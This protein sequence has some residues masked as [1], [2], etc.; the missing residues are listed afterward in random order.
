MDVAVA[1]GP[2]GVTLRVVGDRWWHRQGNGYVLG[3]VAP[4]ERVPL[5]WERAFGGRSA[6]PDGERVERRN[7]IGCGFRHPD[8]LDWPDAIP[9]P[10]VEDPAQPHTALGTSG[11]PAGVLPIGAHWWPRPQW[12]GT[13]DD[14]WQ[15]GRAPYLPRDFDR[16]FLHVAP[17]PLVA[18]APLT[19]G[20]PIQCWGLTPEGYVASRV[21]VERP[22]VTWQVAGRRESAAVAIDTILLD[23]SHG[24]F[25]VCWRTQLRTDKETLKVRELRIEGGAFA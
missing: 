19:G 4:F 16:R 23:P 25:T 6:L 11:Q 20:E 8:T 14:A 13:Y 15:R 5:V 7:P 3:D 9:A 1:V 17:P 18:A 12:A 10:N 2:V 21:P 24:C 22:T